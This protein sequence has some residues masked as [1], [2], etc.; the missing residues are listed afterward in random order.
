M[1]ATNLLNPET[2]SSMDEMAS[3]HCTGPFECLKRYFV[4][5]PVSTLQDFPVSD[6]ARVLPDE[7]KAPLFLF[8]QLHATSTEPVNLST[9]WNSELRKQRLSLS[10]HGGCLRLST[11]ACS[12]ALKKALP[13]KYG[14]D[15]IWSAIGT[16][17]VLSN[18]V[19]AIDLSENNLVDVADLV[20]I[21]DM[22]SKFPNCQHIDLSLN[23][24][25]LERDAKDALATLLENPQ[26][27][28]V[29]I[30]MNHF[31]PYRLLID[32]PLAS[33]KLIWIPNAQGELFRGNWRAVCPADMLDVVFEVHHRYYSTELLKFKWISA[34]ERDDLTLALREFE[35]LRHLVASGDEAGQVMVEISMFRYRVTTGAASPLVG[36]LTD[37]SRKALKCIYEHS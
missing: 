8:V 36:Y 15:E 17:S 12:V 28:T 13:H 11:R 22:V 9:I 27:V 33:K 10:V 21:D 5:V 30:T 18:D 3:V 34:K 19:L 20:G 4:N 16:E 24:F 23:L 7:D 26:L 37:S 31:N 14:L 1:S 29:N 6:F 32:I 35:W 2:E 25:R